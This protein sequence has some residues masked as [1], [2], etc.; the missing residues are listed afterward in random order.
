[1]DDKDNANRTGCK[2]SRETE[3]SLREI[4][5]SGLTLSGISA[6]DLKAQGYPVIMVSSVKDM[7]KTLPIGCC[8]TARRTKAPERAHDRARHP[9]ER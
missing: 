1:M 5:A 3:R 6:A 4:L 8:A 7:R 2:V 9:S